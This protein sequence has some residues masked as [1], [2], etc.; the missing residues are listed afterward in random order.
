[1]LPVEELE[2]RLG[3]QFC[4]RQLLTRA[5]THRSRASE[6]AMPD[7]SADNEQLEFLGDS[8]L[9]FLVSEAL[10][11]RNPCAREGS[12]SRLKGHLVSSNHLHHCAIDLGLGEHVLLGKG[13]ERNG[14]RERKSLLA[15]GMEAI[16]AAIYLDGGM[17]P[18]RR[19]VGSHILKPLDSEEDV[20]SIEQLNHKSIVQERSQALGLPTPRYVTLSSSGPEHAKVFIVEGRIGEGICARGS[21]SSKK[22]ASQIAAELLLK[23]LISFATAIRN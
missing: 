18:A 8:V 23:E 7:A 21:A 3:Y 5:L 6:S 4:D 11:A 17:E 22:S 15:D 13:E 19:F 2:T 1:M 16:L 12:L 20:A 9:G 14:G 10:V